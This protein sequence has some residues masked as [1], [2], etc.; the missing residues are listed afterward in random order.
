MTKRDRTI[1]VL[2]F[3][4]GIAIILGSY[5]MLF[6]RF[7]TYGLFVPPAV[8]IVGILVSYVKTGNVLWY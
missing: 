8:L 5:A 2:S 1:I 4:P 7:W 6:T 3:V